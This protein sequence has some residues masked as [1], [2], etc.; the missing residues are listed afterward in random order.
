MAN[1]FN[2]ETVID[3]NIDYYA[4]LGLE[5][6]CLPE[7]NTRQ[8][9]ERITEIL[10]MAY[11][12]S[13]F[14]THPDFAESNEEREILHEKF[15]LVVRSHTILSNPLYRSY[16]ESAGSV[17]PTSVEDGSTMEVDWSKV[18][19][20]REGMLE[21]TIG[22]GIFLQICDR[23]E[24][25][26]LIPAF[27]P[28]LESHNFEWDFVIPDVEIRPGEPVKLAIACVND[29]GAVLRLTSKEQIEKSLP[30]KIFFCIPR[31][32]LTFL[33]S[34]KQEF[35]VGEGDNATKYT[36]NGTLQAATYSDYNL[37]ETTNI[38]E[39]VNYICKDGKLD[40]DL[41]AFRNG[42]LI[43]DKKAEDAKL[44]QSQWLTTDEVKERDA[45]K[46]RS[47]LLSKTF[48]TEK[49]DKAADFI[50]N[51]PDKAT[52]RKAQYNGS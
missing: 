49:N 33:R 11:K 32:A 48:F 16:Y 42:Q 17:R 27:R 52:R 37:L 38:E 9:R 1:H 26:N 30:F 8:E 43:I 34:P 25:L 45:K 39:V 13:A 3:F 7:G 51:L 44:E 2:P 19:T 35:I 36:L 4:L 29:E 28:T 12:K 46:L 5:K 22:S 47:I 41:E 20:Y 18:G 14:S 40:Q 21:D 24:E 6:G 50:D 10:N 31:A 15:K 23:L